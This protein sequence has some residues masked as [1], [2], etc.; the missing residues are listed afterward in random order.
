MLAI[1]KKTIIFVL[2]SFIVCLETGCEK[3]FISPANQST[4]FV[5][6]YG[7]VA[8]Q[9]TSDLIATL[10]GGYIMVGSTNSYTNNAETDIFV[11]KTDSLGNEMWSSSF[12]RRDGDADN[13][14]PNSYLKYDEKGVKIFELPDGSGYTV[15]ANRTYVK[16]A[17]ASALKSE[18]V[19]TKVVMYSLDASGVPTQIAGTEIFGALYPTETD[20][21][22]DMK[23]DSARNVY[24]LTGLTT[25]V[26]TP[27]LGN[28]QDIL[29]VT[30]RP[31]FSINGLW[32]Q[33]AYGFEG[34][35]YGTSVQ[36]LDNDYLV[37]GVMTRNYGTATE[38]D[39]VP[40]IVTVNMSKGS[41]NPT[42]PQYFGDQTIHFDGGYS[43]YD[44][45]EGIITIAAHIKAGDVSS[46]NG[47]IALLQIEDQAL[48][49]VTPSPTSFNSRF[50]DL[51][52]GASALTPY[53]AGSIA[54]LPNN[55]GF[56]L[57]TTYY[58]NETNPSSKESSAYLV[59]FDQNL[60]MVSG[61][62]YSFGYANSL[63]ANTEDIAGTVLPVTST[64]SGGTKKEITGYI[65]TGSFFVGTN[66]MMGLVKINENGTLTP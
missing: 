6:Y 47:K 28:E 12:G 33:Y 50:Y 2:L 48:A 38:P 46:Y 5:K 62:P 31:D 32:S 43:V 49:S 54:L 61:W 66:K 21:V 8:D 24:V 40:Q 45:L 23:F 18:E 65:F 37:C 55:E 7:H 36:I 14:Y 3:S 63:V 19:L 34:N 10:D 26:N 56:I 13:R 25:N 16:Y 11:V 4:A 59:K 51:A 53:E 39:L 30:C 41:G 57:S 44:T 58:A 29:T 42:N 35:D 15:A 27:I 22:R 20:E 52:G 9:S 60:D 64:I 17:S 1:S